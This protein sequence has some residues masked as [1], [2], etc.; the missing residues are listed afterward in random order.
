MIAYTYNPA[1]RMRRKEDSEF[2]INLSLDNNK[3]LK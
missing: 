3:M 2:L 1:L